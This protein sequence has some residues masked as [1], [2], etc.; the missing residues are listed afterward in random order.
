MIG[1]EAGTVLWDWALNLWGLGYL[2]VDSVR[3]GLNCR[4]P[5]YCL[6]SW[7]IGWR[8]GKKPHIC[9]LK[10][11]E[12]K[13]VHKSLAHM[14]NC[15]FADCIWAWFLKVGLLDWKV[16][17]HVI[18]L[19]VATFP[20]TETILFY[21]PTSNIWERW[22]PYNLANKACSG[23]L[24]F[25]PRYFSVVLILHFP[26]VSFYMF[27]NNLPFFLTFCVCVWNGIFFLIF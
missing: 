9:C 19:N 22:L 4:T 24:G 1:S 26:Y 15:N 23:M 25:L 2:L 3:I 14:S 7:K 16:S 12:W 20:F 8:V 5:S 17:T 11:C 27:K 18:L 10:S 6:E 13:I 21:I